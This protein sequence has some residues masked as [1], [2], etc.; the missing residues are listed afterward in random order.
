[1]KKKITKGK[2]S[3]KKLVAAF[4]EMKKKAPRAVKK[5]LAKKGKKAANKQRVAIAFSKARKGK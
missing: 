1:M 5:T 3:K 4:K 2:V